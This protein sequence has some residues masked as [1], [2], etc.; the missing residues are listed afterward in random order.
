MACAG[1]LKAVIDAEK[2]AAVY[3]DTTGVGAVADRLCEQG[4]SK[5]VHSVV[6]SGK[7]QE[8][9]RMD[10]D[11]RMIGGFQNRRAEMYH[12][13]LE[14][15]QS[16]EGLKLPNNDEL[17]ADLTCFTSRHDSS[18]RMVLESKDVIRRK[19]G[20]SPDLA[21]A[22]A[23]TFADGLFASGGQS[24]RDPH[25]NRKLVYRQVGWR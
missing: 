14:A 5:I 8:Q 22:V 6:F 1:W 9:Q 15:L 16:E 13:L 7:A 18:G 21:D 23:L 3:V 11:G 20:R 17:H 19:L 10:T 4:Y 12:R 24:G 2:P 25:F